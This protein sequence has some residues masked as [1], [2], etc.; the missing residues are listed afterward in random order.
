[1]FPTFSELL[2]CAPKLEVQVTLAILQA[3]LWFFFIPFFANNVV[4]PYFDARPDKKANFRDLQQRNAKNAFMI[5]FEPNEAY[6]FGCMFIPVLL[7]HGLGGGLCFPSLLGLSFISKEAAIAMACHGALCEV[8]W[9]IQDGIQRIWAYTPFGSEAS[10]KASPPAMNVIM[11]MHHTLGCSM[12]IPM[13]MNYGSNIW[14]HEGIFLL[15]FAAFVAMG[16]QNYGYILDISK[17][18]E[19]LQMKF[20]V[21]VVFITMTYSRVLR[22]VYVLYQLLSVFWLDDQFYFFYGGLFASVLMGILNCLFF[23]DSLAKFTKFMKMASTYEK[24]IKTTTD[25]PTLLRLTTEMRVNS[26]AYLS[27]TPTSVVYQLTNSRRQWAKVK[28]VVKMGA[29]KEKYQ[30]HPDAKQD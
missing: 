15:Q 2:W 14:Y 9:E 30:H 3:V 18:G 23:L 21:T 25:K 16:L 20:L 6:E 17:P 4:K 22:Y 19:M 1:M 24:K 26:H 28:G 12:V 29:L 11:F 7:Q 13:N 5:D 27:T 8:G 10:R